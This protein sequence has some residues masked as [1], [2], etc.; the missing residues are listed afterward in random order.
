M[1]RR[2]FQGDI[3]SGMYM[4]KASDITKVLTQTM[5]KEKQSK[6]DDQCALNLAASEMNGLVVIDHNE[7]VFKNLSYK[8]RKNL[9]PETKPFP[10]I[11]YSFPGTMSAARYSRVFKEYAP[12]IWPEILA[13]IIVIIAAVCLFRARRRSSS[14]SRSATD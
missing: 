4:G 8:E 7:L 1:K 14:V 6:G 12:I 10:A 5:K 11:F 9:K 13:L 3:N 2:I